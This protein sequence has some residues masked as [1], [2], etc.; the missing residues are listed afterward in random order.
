MQS[1]IITSVQASEKVLQYSAVTEQYSTEID[2]YS[3]NSMVQYS[4]ELQYYSIDGVP[5]L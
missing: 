5:V 4:T 3:I 1:C 2:W